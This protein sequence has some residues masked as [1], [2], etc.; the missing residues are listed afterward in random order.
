MGTIQCSVILDRASKTLFDETKV[1][2]GAAEILDYF[3]AGLSWLVLNKPDAYT[4]VDKMQLADGALQQL[5]SGAVQ[6]LGNTMQNMGVDGNSPGAVIRQIERNELDHYAP[7]WPQETGP[8]VVHFTYDPTAA[9]YFNVW[10]R[11]IGDW[12]VRATWAATPPRVTDPDSILSVDDL[13]ESTLHYFVVGHALLK[14]SL[15]GDPA[16]AGSYLTMAANT[17]GLKTKVQFA[18]APVDPDIGVRT[19]QDL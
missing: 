10:P 3:N 7:E 15:K 12:H 13:Y 9:K 4:V 19:G 17:I 1:R 18:F 2:W 14:N 5:P 16:K 11:P 6:L 8:A